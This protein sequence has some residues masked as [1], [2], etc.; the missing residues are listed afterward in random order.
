MEASKTDEAAGLTPGN[1]DNADG[2]LFSPSK[3]V[4]PLLVRLG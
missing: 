2:L 1:E 3:T 4:L